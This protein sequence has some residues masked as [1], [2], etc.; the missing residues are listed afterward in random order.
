[1][2]HRLRMPYEEARTRLELAA[3]LRSRDEV[4]AVVEVQAAMK[5]FEGLGA[6]NDTDRAAAMLRDLGVRGGRVPRR[7]GS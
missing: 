3:A 1:M 5:T 4:L 6:R 7:S 2:F